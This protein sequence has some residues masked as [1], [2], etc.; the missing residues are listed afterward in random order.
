L[1]KPFAF[2]EAFYI[3]GGTMAKV[4]YSVASQVPKAM[5]VIKGN[6]KWADVM[7]GWLDD[8]C[9]EVEDDKRLNYQQKIARMGALLLA[10]TG[11]KAERQKGIE[12]LGRVSGGV[13]GQGHLA[14]DDDGPL[15]IEHEPTILDRGFGIAGGRA[16]QTSVNVQ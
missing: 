11:T 16:I 6:K 12:L 10:T 15:V 7:R 3:Q 4:D 5:D 9:Q 2:F 8:A 13:R 14:N 1:L